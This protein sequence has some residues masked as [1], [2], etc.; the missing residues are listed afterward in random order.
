VVYNS[1]NKV[2]RAIK[3]V[4]IYE[5]SDVQPPFVLKEPDQSQQP[6][7]A[8]A[9]GLETGLREFRRLIRYGHVLAKAM[10]EARDIIS[11]LADPAKL[12]NLAVKIEWLEQERKELAPLVLAYDSSQTKPENRLVSTNLAE[13]EKILAALY[14]QPDN[15]DLIVRKFNIPGAEPLQAMI[16]YLDGMIDKQTVNISI[17][18]PLMLLSGMTPQNGEDL[19]QLVINEYLPSNQV[20]LHRKFA[21]I[22]DGIN[23]GDTAIFFT[24]IDQA[25]IVETKGFEHR[26]IERPQIEQTI[27]GSQ[28]AFCEILRINT[29]LIRTILPTSDLVTEMIPVGKRV[30]LYAAIMYLKSVANPE[31]VVEIK[32][33][34]KGINTDYI[35]E[36]GALLQF[37]EDYP[38]SLFPQSM[39]TERPDRVAANLAEGR[40]AILLHGSP[41]AYIVPVSFF[42]FFQ[43]IEDFAL[44]SP[45]GTFM[46]ILRLLGTLLAVTLPAIYLG[47]NYFHQEALP[48]ELALAIAAA[49]EQVPF[50]ALIEIMLMEMSFELIREAGLRVPGLLGSTIGIVGAIVLGQAAVTAKIVS[51]IMVVIIAITG[52]GSFAIP[53]YRLA[54]GLRISRFAFLGL[55]AWLGLVGVAFGLF[56]FTVSMC[57]MKSFGM[58]FMAPIGPRTIAGVDVIVRGPVYRQERRPDELDTLD[59]QRQPSISRQWVQEPPVGSENND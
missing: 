35:V 50:P 11:Q 59:I 47:I 41:F 23:G 2:W 54:F 24:G 15:R 49:R 17:L 5:P 45:A 22:V 10:E 53:D 30:P 25:I 56:L 1:L 13:N 40:V 36:G 3:R 9:A 34:L 14:H 37:I 19:L 7:D 46:R 42:S 29:A 57:S 8:P 20:Q 52:L 55:A 27:R 16:V 21:D 28:S 32:R 48:T 18:Q 44:K 26:G 6:A 31:L 33:R 38:R 58:P 43:S 4:I 39:S 12:D 51:P